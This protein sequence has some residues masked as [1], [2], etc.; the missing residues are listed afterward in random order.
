MT[1]TE[2]ICCVLTVISLWLTVRLWVVYSRRDR[3]LRDKL[4]LLCPSLEWM[5]DERERAFN[6]LGAD[7]YPDG[8][9]CDWIKAMKQRNPCEASVFDLEEYYSDAE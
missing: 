3:R 6:L 7:D 8:D 5:K 1:I 4:D 2:T 9:L